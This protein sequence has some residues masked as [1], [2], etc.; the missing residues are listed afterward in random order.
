V[1]ASGTA[2]SLHWVAVPG[3]WTLVVMNADASRSVDVAVAGSVTV[4]DLGQIGFLV[5]AIALAILGGGIW[6]TARAARA[7]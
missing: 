6:L 3:D 5:L 4:P 1:H 2:P 7:P